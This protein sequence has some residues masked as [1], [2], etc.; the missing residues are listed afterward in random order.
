MCSSD[1]FWDAESNT[2]RTKSG[3]YEILYGTS[4]QD[5]DL[6]TLNVNVNV[7]DNENE[8]R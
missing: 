4:S 1:L 8:K 2:M 7:N 3:K 5:K 6:K